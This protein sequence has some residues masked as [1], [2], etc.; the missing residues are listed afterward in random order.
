MLMTNEPDEH[1]ARLT[2]ALPGRV[3]LPSHSNYAEATTLWSRSPTRLQ[4]RDIA[5][6]ADEEFYAN[7]FVASGNQPAQINA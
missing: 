5:P 7:P 3:I 2:V 4:V 1:I 6:L